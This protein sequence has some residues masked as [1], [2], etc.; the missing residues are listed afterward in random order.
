MTYPWP[1]NCVVMLKDS[2]KF[3]P[4]FN[5]CA[6]YSNSIFIDRF[7]KEHAHQS[8]DKAIEAIKQ[9]KVGHHNGL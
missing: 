1:R 7:S 8:L 4:G 5:V 6:Y 3:L 9:H 2:L